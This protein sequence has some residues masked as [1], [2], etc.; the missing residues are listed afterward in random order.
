MKKF[1]CICSFMIC[2]ALSIST[3]IPTGVFADNDSVGV[4]SGNEYGELGEKAEILNKLGIARLS[5]DLAEGIT[6]GYYINIIGNI[7][8]QGTEPTYEP[9]FDD[10]TADS[11]YASAIS[12]AYKLGIISGGG[13][14]IQTKLAWYDIQ[15][16]LNGTAVAD[17]E[18]H[19]II[20]HKTINLDPRQYNWLITNIWQGAMHYIAADEVWLWGIND[21]KENG[22]FR[23]TTMQY[24]ADCMSG[25]GKTMSDINRLSYEVDAFKNEAA[26]VGLFYSH[27]SR[28]LDTSH[29]STFY[30][31][32][33]NTLYNGYK[34]CIVT[35]SH[36]SDLNN[37][38]VFVVPETLHTSR[39]SIETVIDYAKS[40]GRVILLGENTFKYD[41]NNIEHPRELIDELYSVSEVIPTGTQ[42]GEK[43]T[44]IAAQMF[45]I[46]GDRYD[47]VL[48]PSYSLIDAD[49]G[50]K[51][52]NTEWLAVESDGGVI[53]NMLNYEW[54]TAKKVK[55]AAG[56]KV[57][58]GENLLSGDSVGEVLSLEPYTPTFVKYNK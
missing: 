54:G 13:T 40:G 35:E 48:K 31:S 51:V 9:C 27:A 25:I 1:L 55:L 4:S 45:E 43:K 57:L 46:L 34:P 24:R 11:E 12:C 15:H 53:V 3:I 8:W 26:D 28:T 29:A 19:I 30:E 47:E 37:Y 52:K 23:N 6:R 44:A 58:T 7:L 49:T 32:Y 38:K 2:A 50:E 14:T 5:G 42:P 20:D 56:G 17:W 18:N 21:E 39:E 10:V 33:C 16:S 36:I 22:A 41:L